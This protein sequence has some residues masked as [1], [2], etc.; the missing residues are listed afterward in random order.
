MSF[1][2]FGSSQYSVYYYDVTMALPLR[3]PITD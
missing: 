3:G 1:L 2:Y